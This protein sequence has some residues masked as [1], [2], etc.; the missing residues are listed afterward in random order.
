MRQISEENIITQDE[1]LV[2]QNRNGN[3]QDSR[4]MS[5]GTKKNN[6]FVGKK[7]TGECVASPPSHVCRGEEITDWPRGNGGINSFVHLV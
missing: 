5:S 1:L 2:T 7:K 4:E 3:A 6:S